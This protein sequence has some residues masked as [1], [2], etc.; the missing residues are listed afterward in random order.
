M[1]SNNLV[2]MHLSKSRDII[3]KAT[4]KLPD[5]IKTYNHDHQLE[6]WHNTQEP[7]DQNTHSW[8]PNNDLSL[9]TQHNKV[10]DLG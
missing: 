2:L 5:T 1:D 10:I 3:P 4:T 6:Y 9:Q 7:K 8:K